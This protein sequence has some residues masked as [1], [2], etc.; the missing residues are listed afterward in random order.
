MKRG[1][2]RRNPGLEPAPPIGPLGN[3]RIL[4]PRTPRG[5][6]LGRSF[7][8]GKITE[9]TG[10][11]TVIRARSRRVL[12]SVAWPAQGTEISSLELRQEDVA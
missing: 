1:E 9:S 8:P 6:A 3:Q 2:V 7:T 4:P 5:T 12:S 10:S 11:V